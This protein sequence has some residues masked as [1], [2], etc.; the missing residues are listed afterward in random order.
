MNPSDLKHFVENNPRLVTRKE[1]SRFPGL[2][3]LKY[4]RRVFYDALWKT[5]PILNELRG[6]V[7]DDEYNVVCR[8]FTKIFNYL[9]EGGGKTWTDS[10]MVLVTKKLNGFMA[11]VTN[12]NGTMIVS[13]T[14]S[15]D[16]D[17]VSMATEYLKDIKVTDLATHHTYMFEIC[18]PNDPHI[19]EEKIGAHFLA[20]V[21]HDLGTTHYK[22]DMSSVMENALKAFEP[23][24][25]ICSDDDDIP[26]AWKFGD[27]K[28]ELKVCRHEGFVAINPE[29][30]ETIKLKSPYYL[31]K[32]F[33]ARV[34]TDK[35]ISWMRAGQA[36]KRV[37]EEYYIVLEHLQEYG[38]DKF[39]S[40][41][42][43]DR[44]KILRYFIEELI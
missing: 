5:S 29:T 33:L 11:G 36:I 13:T 8:P 3:V 42:E 26:T 14:G 16:S 18:H 44:L 27:L 19:I 38:I 21:E 12:V 20:I 35:L 40:E 43:Q 23:L 24:G 6:L 2:F 4:A 41:S 30:Y 34:S 31:F 25:I 37:D 28:A 15:L 39:A 17:F 22:F 10:T 32:K 1:S 9:E 7:V